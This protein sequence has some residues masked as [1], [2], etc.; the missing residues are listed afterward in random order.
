MLCVQFLMCY[1]HFTG[2]FHLIRLMYIDTWHTHISQN[3]GLIEYKHKLL[4]MAEDVPQI[5]TIG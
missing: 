2:I 3:V 5:R 4:R 1:V